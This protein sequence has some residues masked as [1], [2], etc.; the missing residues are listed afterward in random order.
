MHCGICA[1]MT[2]EVRPCNIG[3]HDVDP[4][5]AD[6]KIFTTKGDIYLCQACVKRI[7]PFCRDSFL[8][9]WVGFPCDQCSQLAAFDGDIDDLPTG[10]VCDDCVSAV[11]LDAASSDYTRGLWLCEPCFDAQHLG[12]KQRQLQPLLDRLSKL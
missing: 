6:L 11:D 8:I 12:H 4:L 9:T 10:V 5:A 1:N 7:S 2:V 3:A